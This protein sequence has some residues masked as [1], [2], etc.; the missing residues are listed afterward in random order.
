MCGIPYWVPWILVRIAAS[1]L[2]HEPGPM[3]PDRTWGTGGARS[4][5]TALGQDGFAAV[6][7]LGQM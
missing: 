1:Q 6:S 4:A 3:S 2:S 5:P 7:F